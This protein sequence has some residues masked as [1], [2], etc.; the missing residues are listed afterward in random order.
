MGVFWRRWT[1]FTTLDTFFAEG[2]KGANVTVPFKEEAFARA[3][4]LTERAALAGAVNTLN[5][6]RMGVC[7]GTTPTGLD[8]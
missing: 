5:G 8:Y 1:I 6:W 3:D 4:E 2:G 7:W